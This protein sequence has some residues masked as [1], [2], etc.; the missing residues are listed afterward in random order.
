MSKINGL[1]SA[2]PTR[3][4]FENAYTELMCQCLID[5]NQLPDAQPGKQGSNGAAGAA[6]SNDSDAHICQILI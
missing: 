4:A 6:A 1:D 2:L 5:K 3:S